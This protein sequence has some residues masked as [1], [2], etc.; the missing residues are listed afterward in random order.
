M[1]E[2]PERKERSELMR[3]SDEELSEYVADVFEF[4]FGLEHDVG[5]IRK[6]LGDVADVLE[7]RCENTDPEDYIYRQDAEWKQEPDRSR[8]YQVWQFQRRVEGDEL[9]DRVQNSR[10]GG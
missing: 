6:H 9:E 7:F 5:Q 2:L 1:T 10:K 4:L 8:P 3:M